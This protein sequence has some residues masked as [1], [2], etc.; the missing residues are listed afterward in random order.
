MKIPTALRVARNL[1][2]IP[3]C[4]SCGER[5]SP[6]PKRAEGPT[7]GRICFCKSCIGKWLSA[8]AEACPVCANTSDKCNCTQN[9]FFN[10][11]PEIPSLCFY[12][13]ESGDA[14]SRAILSMKRRLDYETFDFMAD[15]LSERLSFTL[16]KMK[17]NGK[18]CIFTWIPRKKSSIAENGFDQARELTKRVARRNGAA[19]YP[20]L[21]RIGGK[22][23][24]RLD[25]KDRAKNAKKSIGLNERTD[26][27][28]TKSG[29]DSVKDFLSGKTVIIIDD[30]M[31]SGA[32]LRHACEILQSAGA[33]N[34]VVA[35][36]AKSVKKNSKSNN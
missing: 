15:E 7:R 28:P 10:N 22:E 4:A 30:I 26:F 32:T 2:F 19:A 24:K 20:L 8:R 6:L 23:Q 36:L 9:Y 18:D 33:K 3:R 1:I 29:A 27:I 25:S 16:A 13:P 17:L 31:T 34:T 12:R 21:V 5:L 11:Q 14:Q 35:C